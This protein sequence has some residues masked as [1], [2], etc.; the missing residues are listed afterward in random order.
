MQRYDLDVIISDDHVIL[1]AED[2]GEAKALASREE[3]VVWAPQRGS[4]KSSF[5]LCFLR[6]EVP[7]TG[8]RQL[9]LSSH[10]P[11]RNPGVQRQN[12]PG[13][14]GTNRKDGNAKPVK[15]LHGSR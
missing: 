2:A 1:R 7:G 10:R 13:T 11:E 14:Q 4:P 3:S 8:S 6:V 12:R 15:R 5:G 9:I